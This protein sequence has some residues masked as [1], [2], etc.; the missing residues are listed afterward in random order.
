MAKVIGVGGI[1]FK[2][3]DKDALN[4]WYRDVLG[5]DNG[6]WGSAIFQPADMVSH[7]GACT[8]FGPFKDDTDYILPSTKDFMINLVVDDLDAM[9][10]RCREHGVEPTRVFPDEPNGRF[11]HIIDPEGTKIELW[12]PKPMA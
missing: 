5:I 12:E 3:K 2:S 9:L 4:T 6:D 7:P 10:V 8:V 1:F 11:A